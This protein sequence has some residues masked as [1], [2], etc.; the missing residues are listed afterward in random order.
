MFQQLIPYENRDLRDL[1]E[2]DS[3]V[4][5]SLL[6]RFFPEYIQSSSTMYPFYFWRLRDREAGTRYLILDGEELHRIPGNSKAGVHI[7]TETG[8]LVVTSEFLTGYR[9]DILDARLI[10]DNMIDVP[11]LEI[12]SQPLTGRNIRKQFYGL[13]MDKVLLVRLED[14]RHKIARNMYTARHYII[15]PEVPERSVEDCETVLRADAPANTLALLTWMSGIHGDNELRSE[16]GCLD[17]R[18][19]GYDKI[20]ESRI[21]PYLGVSKYN[22]TIRELLERKFVRERLKQLT[23]SENQWIREAAELVIRF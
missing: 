13:L 8:K 4:F 10:E 15:G 11:V 14:D 5:M 9:I 20:S 12:T 17:Q 18:N 22:E 23:N 1:D 7:F 3:E 2:A 21:T 19:G 6:E 16:A